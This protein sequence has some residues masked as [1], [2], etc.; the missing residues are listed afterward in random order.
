VPASAPATKPI[1]GL[2]TA[3]SR[4]DSAYFRTVAQLGIQA[5]EALDHAHQQGIIHRDIKPGNLLVNASGRLWVSDFGLAQVQSDARLTM[6]GDLV[7]TLRYMSPE[8]ALAKRILV[9]QRADIYSLGATLYELL[10]LEPVFGGTDRQEILRQIAF[11]EP[12][13]PRRINKAIPAELETIVLK[14][15]EKRPQDRYATAQELADDLRHWCEDRPIK[16]R[17]PTFPQVAAR[18]VRRHK[19]LVWSVG[20]VLLIGMVFG[21]TTWTWWAQ[22]RVKA[23]ESAK[24]ALVE[25]DQWQKEE[26]WYEALSAVRRADGVL[27]DVGADPILSHQVSRRNKD[28]EMARRLEEARLQMAIEKDG[29]FDTKALNTAY[30]EAFRWYEMDVDVLDPGEAGEVVRS[31]S[32]PNQLVAALDDWVCTRILNDFGSCKHLLAIARLADPDPWR[33]RLRDVMDSRNGKL[34]DELVGS[35]ESNELAPVSAVTL[36]RVAEGWPAA[37]QAQL[38]LRKVHLRYPADFWLNVELG[39]SYL[40]SQPP[41]LEES[42]PYYTVAV[43][44][45]PQSAGTHANLGW[46]LH[47]KGRQGDAILEHREALRFDNN[48]AAAHGNLG[49][50]LHFNGQLEEAIA[51]TRVAIGLQLDVGRYHYSLGVMLNAKGESDAAIASFQESLRLDP[52]LAAMGHCQIAMILD[53]KKLHEEAI[54]EF[55]KAISSKPAFLESY[56][57]LGDSLI[58]RGRLDK[59]I[60]VY[61]QAIHLKID[62]AET[63]NLLGFAMR[64]QGKLDE[65]IAEFCQA[66]RLNPKDETYH[67]NYGQCLKDKDRLDDAIAE[68]RRAIDF[69]K[70]YAKAHLQ[71]GNAL[72]KKDRLD[73]AI[74]EFGLA[75]EADKNDPVSHFNLAHALY[76]KNRP[77]EAI[78]ELRTVI[79]LNK[80]MVNAHYMLGRAL[81]DNGK[82]DEAIQEYREAIRLK[83]DL[84]DAYD[85]LGWCLMGKNRNAEAIDAYRNAIRIDPDFAEPHCNLGLLLKDQGQF[86]EALKELRRG[87]ELGLRDPQWRYPSAKWVQDTQT[88][89]RVD[90]Q[91]T[92]VLEGKGLPK[93]AAERIAFARLCQ[94]PFRQH[95]KL[96]VRFYEEAF[97]AEPNLA[98]GKQ[99]SDDRY[100]AACAA[101]LAGCGQGMDAR[102]TP[103]EERLRFRQQALAWLK[104]E[105]TARQRHYTNDPEKHRTWFIMGLRHWLNDQD[106]AG[107]RDPKALAKVPASERQAWE[108]LWANLA[109]TLALAQKK[110]VP[111]TKAGTK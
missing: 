30:A 69:N 37:K 80:E 67:F 111:E 40:N 5:A 107:V 99:P 39:R 14:A 75:V 76:D 28:L 101:S 20:V 43:A 97:A 41:Q 38:V 65:A 26:R 1:A 64:K 17:R 72:I 81:R 78:V 22:K 45:R 91:L 50:I 108:E 62:N 23:E 89:L 57:Q 85:G 98:G 104:E 83:P 55:R 110:A 19:P 16:A 92:S 86:K 95:Y 73:E 46:I 49:T 32:I 71:L 18:W 93:N 84:S 44:L 60:A 68:Y 24:A 88:Q 48:F 96:S 66:I 4:K 94:Q 54:A 61:R 109:E 15:L 27:A 74:A 7:G 8:Q 6:T 25:A 33:N 77:E 100:N 102:D 10:T 34:L 47:K 106:F 56:H 52:E 79:R 103:M 13:S 90:E 42:L 53:K 11:E 36:H 12:K 87:H 63:H 21:G 2:T 58:D 105:F 31:S 51:E 29:H 70:N 35:A 59:G 9:D 3:L 82:L